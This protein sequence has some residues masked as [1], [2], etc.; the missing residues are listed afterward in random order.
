MDELEADWQACEWAA[1]RTDDPN[2]G[3]GVPTKLQSD[4]LG[5][6]R[7]VEPHG[8]THLAVVSPARNDS[9]R[10]AQRQRRDEKVT[11]RVNADVI[12]DE[13]LT[14][15]PRSR[16]DRAT[17][18]VDATGD[19]RAIVVEHLARD[20]ARRH[21]RDVDD[22]FSFA[23]LDLHVAILEPVAHHRSRL[24]RNPSRHRRIEGG[25]STLERH[26]LID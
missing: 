9:V 24:V 2:F 1:V 25:L 19:R 11:P 7:L 14:L 10:T 20:R 16:L 21:G 6:F 18:D 3:D 5:D 22:R 15:K 23:R 26:L 12:P 8:W 17:T 4:A 13:D